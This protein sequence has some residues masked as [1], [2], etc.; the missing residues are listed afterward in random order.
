MAVLASISVFI[1]GGISLLVSTHA[2]SES[3]VGGVLQLLGLPRYPHAL[4]MLIGN[5]D[6]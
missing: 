6:S 4:V 3:L 5:V 1:R 2:G